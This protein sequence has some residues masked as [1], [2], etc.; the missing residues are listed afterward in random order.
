MKRLKSYR[1]TFNSCCLTSSIQAIT[2]NLAPLLFVSFQEGLGISLTKL[3]ALITV[4]FLVQ[5]LMDALSAKIIDKI[6]Y[7]TAVILS[8]AF[9]ALGLILLATLPFALR[10]GYL[11]L[12]IATIV[13]AV[14]GGIAE[15]VISPIVE[16][17]P[18]KVGNIPLLHSFYC[19]GYLLVVLITV[20]YFQFFPKTSWQA[21]VLT[22][23]AIPILNGIFFFFVPCSTLDE[24]R[25]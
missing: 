16:A 2:I 19:F 13:C 12:M 10:D 5:L 24:P 21:L 22:L 8:H 9:S 14:G 7:R 23:S 1:H 11:G 25:G 20:V 3:T 15:V 4:T 18:E 17:I 6:G